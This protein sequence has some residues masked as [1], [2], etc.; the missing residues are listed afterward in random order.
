MTT[1]GAYAAGLPCKNPNCK[2]EGKPHPNCKCYGAMAKGG[3][4]EHFC[5]RNMHHE[6]SCKYFAKGG[7]AKVPEKQEMDPS[8]AISGYIAHHG[9][10]GLLNDKLNDIEKYHD[11]IKKGHKKLDDHTESLF[12]GKS[13]QRQENPKSKQN[14]ENWLT[15]GGAYEDVQNAIS[16][17]DPDS[18]NPLQ[19]HNL[20]QLYPEHN[21]LLQSSK[22]R[23]SNYLNGLKPQSNAPRLAFDSEPDNTQSKKDYSDALNIAHDPLSVLHE[24]KKGT[25]DLLHVK[26]LTSMY[27]ELLESMQKKITGHIIEAQLKKE[28]P[29][30]I[31]RQG[32]SLLMGTPLSGELSPQGIQSAQSTFQSKEQAQ[33]PQAGQATKPK[34]NTSKLSKSDQSFMTGNQALTAR[35]QKQ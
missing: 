31:I 3:E 26:H 10:A 5:S 19:N 16:G 34:K 6:P 35:Q 11:H 17:Q 24:I 29:N 30:Y 2:S 23:V 28:K 27:P 32:L 4:V 7:E 21:L 25:A 20:S 15:K 18:S 13:I 14:L 12:S 33:Q 1:Y 8:H 22:G 9:G